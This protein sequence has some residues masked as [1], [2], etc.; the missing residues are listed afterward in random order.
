MKKRIF[1]NTNKR[2]AVS[3]WVWTKGRGLRVVYRNG[4]NWKSEYTLPEL[5]KSNERFR[6]EKGGV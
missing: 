5:L 6:E 4:C 1:T 3:H 2:S